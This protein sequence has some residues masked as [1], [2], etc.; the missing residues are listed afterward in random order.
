MWCLD[1]P[2]KVSYYGGDKIR[3]LEFLSISRGPYKQVTL[4]FH[5]GD[6]CVII[7]IIFQ[8][9]ISCV[10]FKKKFTTFKKLLLFEG[11][12]GVLVLGIVTCQLA[13]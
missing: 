9:L 2:K 3:L 11:A 10:F 4:F 13:V 5:L 1:L 7:I 12:R 6:E 8:S